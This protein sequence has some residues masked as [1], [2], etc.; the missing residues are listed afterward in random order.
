MRITAITQNLTF[1]LHQTASSNRLQ[2]HRTVATY[3]TSTDMI[4]EEL[5][6]KRPTV[7]PLNRLI[8]ES[9]A[10]SICGRFGNIFRSAIYWEQMISY[11][12]AYNPLRSNGRV[13]RYPSERYD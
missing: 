7:K 9:Y 5:R 3:F 1:K 13:T 6:K 2:T 10:V 8:V 4:T 11:T 12:F